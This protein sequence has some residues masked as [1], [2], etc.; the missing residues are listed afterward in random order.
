MRYKPIAFT[1]N[2][3]RHYCFGIKASCLKLHTRIKIVM[4]TVCHSLVHKS[5]KGVFRCHVTRLRKHIICL[6]V[7]DCVPPPPSTNRSKAFP[8]N[9]S[10]SSIILSALFRLT[11]IF[12]KDV[13]GAATT[14]KVRPDKT[15]LCLAASFNTVLKSNP[16]TIIL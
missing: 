2:A 6:L 8:L 5:E 1:F 12:Y 16:H 13:N 7:S 15:H 10:F 4:F 9:C 14:T 3:L 11:L